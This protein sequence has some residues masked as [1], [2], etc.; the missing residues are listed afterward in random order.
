MEEEAERVARTSCLSAD[1]T[2]ARIAKAV[3]GEFLSGT[4]S[5]ANRMKGT[6]LNSQGI[7]SHPV[8][9]GHDADH[10]P[11]RDDA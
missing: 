10:G 2:S 1:M 7:V 11:M 9:Q 3:G 6:E 8:R 5:F 4:L